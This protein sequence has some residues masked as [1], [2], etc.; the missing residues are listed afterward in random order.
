MEDKEYD[1]CW[2]RFT[3]LLQPYM[4]FKFVLPSNPTPLGEELLKNGCF[5]AYWLII[6]QKNKFLNFQMIYRNVEREYLPKVDT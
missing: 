4:K 6:L 3:K 1:E 5:L 2:K